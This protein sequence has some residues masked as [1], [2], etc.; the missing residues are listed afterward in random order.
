MPVISSFFLEVSI[1]TLHSKGSIFQKKKKR[2][3]TSKRR[4]LGNSVLWHSETSL[5]QNSDSKSRLI[6]QEEVEKLVFKLILC[7]SVVKGFLFSFMFA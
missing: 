5:L 3:S 1:V 7:F 4:E 2:P 6:S